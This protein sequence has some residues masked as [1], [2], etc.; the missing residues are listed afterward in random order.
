MSITKTTKTIVENKTSTPLVLK[1][2]NGGVY[3]PL[4]TLEKD[5]KYTIKCDQNATYREFFIAQ[6]PSSTGQSQS[7]IT[8]TITS[9]DCAEYDLIAIKSQGGRLE[10]DFQHK[11]DNTKVG[12]LSKILTKIGLKWLITG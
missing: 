6:P 4:A 8:A 11:R 9:D 10:V 12:F 2:G 7:P 3:T 5:C 1:A